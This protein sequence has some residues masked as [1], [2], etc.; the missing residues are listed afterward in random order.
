MTIVERAER[1]LADDP[2]PAT[3]RELKQLLDRN[4]LDA[5]H[6]RFDSSLAFRSAS[7][8]GLLGAGPNRMNR[9]TVIRA[10]AGLCAWLRQQLPNAAER[11]ICVGFDGRRMSRELATDAAGVIAG[12]VALEWE[13]QP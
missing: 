8:R 11:G 9:V 12:G 7:F 1:W 2:D 6:D 13:I 10:T 5:L 3:R 4:D